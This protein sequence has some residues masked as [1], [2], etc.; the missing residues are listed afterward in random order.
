MSVLD[1]TQNF[2]KNVMEIGSLIENLSD[3]KCLF[4]GSIA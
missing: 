1:S 2:L 4:L 3:V